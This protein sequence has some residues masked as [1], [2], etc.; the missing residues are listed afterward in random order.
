MPLERSAPTDDGRPQCSG[1][2][3]ANALSPERRFQRRVVE[4]IADERRLAAVTRTVA[5]LG[6]IS[7]VAD[8]SRWRRQDTTT[9]VRVWRSCP[10]I[11]GIA[12]DAA[13]RANTV[14]IVEADAKRRAAVGA[15]CRIA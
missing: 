11:R 14:R 10:A 5:E 7:E 2:R 13:M 9:A 3:R 12:E 6:T 15:G 4:R 1:G 8:V